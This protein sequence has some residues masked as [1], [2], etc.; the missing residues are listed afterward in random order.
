MTDRLTVFHLRGI[1]VFAWDRE[2]PLPDEIESRYNPEENRYELPFDEEL[3]TLR[4]AVEVDVVVD[5]PERFQVEFSRPPSRE[6]RSRAVHEERAG[7]RSRLL[8]PTEAAV[9]RAV[10][11]GGSRLE[12]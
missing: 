3:E 4:E 12:E 9:E 1:Y 6:I 11:A 10:E 8:F 2:E 7:G 5:T